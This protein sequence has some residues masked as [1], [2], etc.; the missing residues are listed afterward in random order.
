M[1]YV[2]LCIML[3]CKGK[4]SFSKIRCIKSELKTKMTPMHLDP[5][6]LLTTESHFKRM[7]DFNYTVHDFAICINSDDRFL[8][9]LNNYLLFNCLYYLYSVTQYFTHI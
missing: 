4:H 3:N 5:L 9:Q 1:V 2:E 8:A 7:L 6:S